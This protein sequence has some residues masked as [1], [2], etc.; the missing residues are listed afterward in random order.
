M[1]FKTFNY[2]RNGKINLVLYLTVSFSILPIARLHSSCF[3]S[4]CLHTSTIIIFTVFI[5]V[6]LFQSIPYFNSNKSNFILNYPMNSFPPFYTY[7][8]VH[9][10]LSSYFLHQSQ[11]SISYPFHH[12][13]Q[14]LINI[15]I[16]TTCIYRDR[17][18]RSIFYSSR[19][20]LALHCRAVVEST[21][22]TLIIQH[23]D[24][25]TN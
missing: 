23:L 25:E 13:R 15:N 17:H 20:A 4:T 8:A 10:T 11:L 16:I 12:S 22:S 6:Q 19:F 14:L 7:I 3:S 5:R 21:T 18:T 24:P 9:P 2:C 1:I